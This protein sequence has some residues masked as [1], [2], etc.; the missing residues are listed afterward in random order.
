M[1]KKKSEKWLYLFKWSPFTQKSTFKAKYWNKLQRIYFPFI[2]WLP[3]MFHGLMTG[4]NSRPIRIS[5]SAPTATPCR[6]RR[7]IV[8]FTNNKLKYNAKILRSTKMVSSFF[9]SKTKVILSWILQQ[10]CRIPPPLSLKKP[11]SFFTV[12]IYLIVCLS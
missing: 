11:L 6:T 4:E 12:Y 8:N 9:V 1:C 3:N 2:I 5:W 10:R 7:F